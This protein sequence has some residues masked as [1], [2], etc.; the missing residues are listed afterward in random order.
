MG[1]P[2]DGEA[3]A[4]AGRVLDQVALARAVAA[5]VG[6]QAAHGVELLVARE[7]QEALAGLAALVV[8]LLHLVDELADQVEHAVAGPDLLPEVGGGVAGPGGRN[9]R[10]AGA[11]ELPLVEGQEA[12]LRASPAG[13]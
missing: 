13:W 8:L 7:D 2:G 12:G 10:V 3:L 1:E 5:G 6:H 4:A 11:A 9:G